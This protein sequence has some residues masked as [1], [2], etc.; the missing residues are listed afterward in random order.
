MAWQKLMD[1]HYDAEGRQYGSARWGLKEYPGLFC[2]WTCEVPWEDWNGHFIDRWVVFFAPPY[3]GA[4]LDCFEFQIAMRLN[5]QRFS[6]RR[7]A[8]Q[9][10]EIT[11]TLMG[12]KP[13]PEPEPVLR[14]S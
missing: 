5:G 12:G 13:E 11:A 8:L 2:Q 4:P 9:A 6:T 14:F 10:I 1:A 7:D 3:A